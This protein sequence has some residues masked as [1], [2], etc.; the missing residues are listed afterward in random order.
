MKL[1]L[2]KLITGVVV[3]SVSILMHFLTTSQ[4]REATLAGVSPR[5]IPYLVAKAVFVMALIMIGQA[6]YLY[7]RE[8]KT[9]NISRSEVSFQRFPFLLFLLMGAYALAMVYG[10]YFIASFTILPVMM[11][12]LKERKARNYLILA[13]LIIFIFIIIDVL[14]KIRLPKLGLFGI[15]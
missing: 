9:A 4:I 14:L 3:L 5:A 15:I 7:F 12:I 10:G 11:Y 6:L 13:G 1:Y 8:R 2:E